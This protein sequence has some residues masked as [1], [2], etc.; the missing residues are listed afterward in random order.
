MKL[1]TWNVNGIRA[2]YGKGLHQLVQQFQP[3]ILCLQ[4]TKAHREQVEPVAQN[5]GFGHDFWSSAERKGYSSVATF[6]HIHPIKV[7]KSIDCPDYEREG[8]IVWSTY[9]NF[10]LYN[11]YFPNGGSGQ[12]RHHFK[13]KFLKDLA[14]HL[15]FEIRKGREIIV[16]GDYN[17]AH[18][19]IDVY[20][21]VLLANESGFLP[22]ERQWFS[23]F[24]ELGFVDSYRHFNPD[25]RDVY[26]WWSYKEMSRVKNRGWRI[27]YICIT[28]GLVKNLKSC[29]VLMQQEGSD[30]C[31]VIAEFEF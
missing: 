7:V 20:D 10:D 3:D 15:Q 2:S 4:E 19:P 25:K 12:E 11:I 26:S 21:P 13:Q 22:E 8:R 14:E 29:D 9:E 23:Q 31:P 6:S 28:R 16:V 17:I 30:H 27:D 24:L 1:I 18:Q 5:L